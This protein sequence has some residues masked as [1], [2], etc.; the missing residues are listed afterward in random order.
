MIERRRP[1]RERVYSRRVHRIRFPQLREEAR[2]LS[3]IVLLL[4]DELNKAEE[5]SRPVV[6]FQGGVIKSSKIY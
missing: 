2:A 5:S 3:D 4:K 6:S 1:H